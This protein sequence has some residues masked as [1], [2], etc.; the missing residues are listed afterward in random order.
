[1][2]SECN[3]KCNDIM[4]CLTLFHEMCACTICATHKRFFFFLNSFAVVAYDLFILTSRP[5][6]GQAAATYCIGLMTQMDA[7]DPYEQICLKLTDVR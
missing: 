6:G 2:Q 4:E 1:M 3:P 5:S 7:M